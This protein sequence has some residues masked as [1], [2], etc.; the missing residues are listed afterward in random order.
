MLLAN[1]T[2]VKEGCSEALQ[3]ELGDPVLVGQRVKRLIGRFLEP[4]GI[5]T[6]DCWEHVASLL[7]NLSQLQDGRDLLRR[8]STKILPALLPEL[9]SPSVVRRRGIAAAI[10]NCCYETA[11]HDWLLHEVFIQTFA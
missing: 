1:L 3:I 6:I 4:R 11:D 7:C 9:N 2:T 8:R 10:R 5:S